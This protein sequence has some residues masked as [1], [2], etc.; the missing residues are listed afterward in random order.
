MKWN[1]SVFYTYSP[2]QFILTTF[3]LARDTFQQAVANVRDCLRMYRGVLVLLWRARYSWLHANKRQVQ[4]HNIM[5]FSF[6]HFTYWTLPYFLNI[7]VL[8]YKCLK[9]P[10]PGQLPPLSSKMME[11]HQVEVTAHSYTASECGHENGTWSLNPYLDT[12]YHLLA[13][14]SQAVADALWEWMPFR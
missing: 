14:S 5:S 11:V 3:Q 7:E 4:T 10:A 2:F 12:C 13:H 8:L 9:I 6:L 1:P